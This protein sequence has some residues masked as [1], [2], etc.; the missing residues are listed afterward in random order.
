MKIKYSD[1][2]LL[3][4]EIEMVY[5]ADEISFESLTR[6]FKSLHPKIVSSH[7]GSIN[8]SDSSYYNAGDIEI[9]TPPLRQS[10]AFKLLKEVFN[11][12]ERYGYTDDSTGFHVNISPVTNKMYYS[13]NPFELIKSKLWQKI[14]KDFNREGNEYC[15]SLPRTATYNTSL[16]L[17]HK[18]SAGQLS[19]DNL[20]GK[21]NAVSLRNYSAIRSPNS[22]IEVRAM[23][24]KDYHKKYNLIQEHINNILTEFTKSCKV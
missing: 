3:G 5:D 18:I 21:Y 9:K 2:F 12:V 17:F 7:D 16:D 8:L 24:G 6:K 14:K 4:F 13:L 15:N 20:I 22:R 1:K 23:G 11:M 10:E 19:R